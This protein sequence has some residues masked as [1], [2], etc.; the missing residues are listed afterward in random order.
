MAVNGKV[1]AMDVFGSTPLFRK[2]WPKL[3]RSYALDAA[4]VEDGEKA[5][6]LSTREDAREFL[7]SAL[8]GKEESKTEVDGGLVVTRRS[9]GDVVGFGAGVAAED[10]SD[11]MTGFGGVHYSAFSE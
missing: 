4:N 2:L 5:G 7:A 11:G 8:E 3:L 6:K 10:A 9:S 1:E